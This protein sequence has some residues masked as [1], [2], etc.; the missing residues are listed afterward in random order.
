MDANIKDAVR[1]L[2]LFGFLIGHGSSLRS[3]G[4]TKHGPDP[5]LNFGGSATRGRSTPFGLIVRKG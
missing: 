3:L 5:Q 2:D 4:G 1:T